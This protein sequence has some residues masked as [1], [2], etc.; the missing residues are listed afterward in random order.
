MKHPIKQTVSSTLISMSV[1]SQAGA[2]GI[3]THPICKTIILK[4]FK[5]TYSLGV[6]ILVDIVKVIT[7]ETGNFNANV[8]TFVYKSKIFEMV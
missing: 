8:A 6:F 5:V 2:V 3:P 7:Q 4:S 1:G